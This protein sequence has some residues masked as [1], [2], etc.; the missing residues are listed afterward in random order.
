[1]EN[2]IYP[3]IALITGGLLSWFWNKIS[4]DK[5][6]QQ[7]KE[8]AQATLT[9]VEK[10]LVGYKAT[11][12]SQ[13]ASAVNNAKRFQDNIDSLIKTVDQKQN[14]LENLQNASITTSANYQSAR[15]T[16]TEKQNEINRQK[17]ELIKVKKDSELMNRKLAT[18]EA[19]NNVLQHKL[20]TQKLEMEELNK[21]FTTEFENIANKILDTKSQKFT[22]LNKENLN[23]IKS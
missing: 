1:M 22:D 8:S 16:L 23:K 10:E 20:Q 5:K 12:E 13:L 14:E 2:I 11:A 19:E 7:F 15:Q 18:T 3:A 17:D 4:S 6:L 9:T 21:K